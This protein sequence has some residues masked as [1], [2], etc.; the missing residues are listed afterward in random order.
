MGELEVQLNG[1]SRR[2]PTGTTV[3]ALLDELGLGLGPCAV[4]INRCIVPRSTHAS[5]QLQPRDEIE[6]VSFVGGG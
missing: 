6:I 1:E 3:A 2:L 4:E 5:R